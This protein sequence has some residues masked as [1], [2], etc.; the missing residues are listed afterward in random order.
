MI[1]RLDDCNYSTS[2]K[3]HPREE[4]AGYLDHNVTII[5][6]SVPVEF[7]LIHPANSIRA[8]IGN[9]STAFLSVTWLSNEIETLSLQNLLPADHEVG[10][11]DRNLWKTLESIGTQRPENIKNLIKK[12]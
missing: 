7:I 5:P 10:A 1:L 11:D 12:L 2:I 6:Q 3:Y 8:L 4:N 9:V